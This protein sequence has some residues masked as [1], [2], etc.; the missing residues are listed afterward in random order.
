MIYKARAN[1]KLI[2][3]NDNEYPERFI[4]KVSGVSPRYY[5]RNYM[6]SNRSYEVTQGG[7]TENRVR[8]FANASSW[9]TVELWHDF[10]EFRNAVGLGLPA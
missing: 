10:A 6:D 8:I 4:D 5:L 2:V 9:N 3:D 7:N 1:I